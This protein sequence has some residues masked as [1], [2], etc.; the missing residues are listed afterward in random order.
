[1]SASPAGF[2]SFAEPLR[3]SAE[4]DA[5]LAEAMAARTEVLTHFPL[6]RIIAAL[7]RSA[8]A[9]LDPELDERKRTI[10]AIARASGWHAEMIATGID[11]VFSAITET[12]LVALIETE[13]SSAREFSAPRDKHHC[14]PQTLYHALAG[15]VPGQSVPAIVAALL[16]G[17]VLIVRDSERQPALTA[18][19]IAT[20]ARAEPALAAMVLPV[21]WRHDGN[22]AAVEDA[23]LAASSRIELYGTDSTLR[24]LSRRYHVDPRRDV[25][26]H[27]SRISLGVVGPSAKLADT[28][29]DFALDVVMYEGLGCLTPHSLWVEGDRHRA[30]D[31]AELLAAELDTLQGRWPR[32]PGPI[33]DE[34]ARRRFIDAAEIRALSSPDKHC[35]VGNDGSWCVAITDGAEI[36]VGPGR[37]CVSVLPVASLLAVTP[38]APYPIAAVGVAGANPTPYLEHFAPSGCSV[39]LSAGRMQAPPIGWHQDGRGRIADLLGGTG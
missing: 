20:L 25:V 33:G 1:M 3:S 10:A 32:T 38:V 39:A 28:A 7:V 11:F 15:N 34:T 22:D 13:A 16:V 36:P 6:E 19:F 18:A 8:G 12:S 35:L 2:S 30:T 31:F 14:G 23:T 4:F 37:R 24:D 26:L 5:R 9:W 29:K 17:S 27:G 21:H